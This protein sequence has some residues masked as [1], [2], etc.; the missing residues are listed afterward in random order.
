VAAQFAERYATAVAAQARRIQ[1]P[2]D[3]FERIAD[4]FLQVS[5]LRGVLRGAEMAQRSI[6]S[7]NAQKLIKDAINTFA[8]SVVVQSAGSSPRAALELARNVLEHFDEFY[9]GSSIRQNRQMQRNPDQSK[10]TLAREHQ[11]G[12][13]GPPAKHPW[14]VIG[15]DLDEP[16]AS[17]DLVIEAP[18]AARR[19]AQAVAAAIGT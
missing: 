12:L 17:I 18:R 5:A 19:L 2:N 8:T 3:P 6:Q 9:C 4:S 7:R 14:L 16:L 11:I 1:H 13:G 10:E 15:R